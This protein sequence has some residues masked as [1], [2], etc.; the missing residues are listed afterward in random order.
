MH[1]EIAGVSR[2]PE[3]VGWLENGAQGAL[4]R[5]RTGGDPCGFFLISVYADHGRIGPV[6]SR[7]VEAFPSVLHRA[8]Q[9]AGTI[10]DA[11]D[12][13]WRVDLPSMNRVAIAP[14][15]DAGFSPQNLMPWFANG[16]IGH[17]DRYI[18]RDEDQL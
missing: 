4:L 5:A 12:R 3:I 9:M 18:F 10:Q 6:G 11:T 15:L 1:R 13:T 16:E 2:L 14:L 17:W 7:T 8:L